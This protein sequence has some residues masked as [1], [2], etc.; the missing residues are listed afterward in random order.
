AL[1]RAPD[2]MLH[3]QLTEHFNIQ[4]LKLQMDQTYL[5][6]DCLRSIFFVLNNSPN[7]ESISL[8]ISQVPAYPPINEVEFDPD[9]IGDNWDAGFLCRVGYVT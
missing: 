2:D 1:G 7:A 8:R 6:M 4:H 9:N 3:T 5:S